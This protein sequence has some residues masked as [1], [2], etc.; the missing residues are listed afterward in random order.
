[1]E[2]S[3]IMMARVFFPPVLG[4]IFFSYFFSPCPFF[5]F[6][7]RQRILCLFLCVWGLIIFIIII[8]II[9]FALAS[10]F[11]GQTGRRKGEEGRGEGKVA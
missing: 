8:I 1:M 7:I 10:L 3:G 6:G 11:M 2:R 5:P 4:S 9:C